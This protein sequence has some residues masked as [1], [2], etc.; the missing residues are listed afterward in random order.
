MSKKSVA[1]VGA[2][3][4]GLMAAEVLSQYNYDI[5]VFEQMPSAA[6]KFLMAGKTGL[7]ISH[8][9]ELSQFIHRYDQVEW[10]KPWITQ[11]DA[12]WIRAWMDDLGVTSYVG[13]S[14]RIFPL[15]MKA[16][17]LLRAWLKILSNTGVQFH[18]RHKCT[19]IEQKKL[20]YID[21]SL[22]QPIESEKL[23]DAVVLACGAV[24][25]PK[26]GSDGQWQTWLQQHELQPFVASNVGVEFSWSK[27]M[28]PIFG[29]PL[30]RIQAWTSSQHKVDGDIVITHYGF[31]SGVIY[32]LNRTLRTSKVLFL[33]L[34]PHLSE[35][36]LVRKLNYTKKQ[37]LSNIWRKAGLDQVKIALLREIVEKEL[38]QQ[39][40]KMASQ[41][42]N[43][44]ISIEGF[45]PIEEAI[46]CA[47]GVK[48]NVLSPMLELNSQSGIFCCG[49][50]LDW[51]AP[52]GGYLLTACFATGRIA[53]EGAHLFLCKNN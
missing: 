37:S 35:D 46:S 53:G 11:F 15:E 9:E 27:Y 10:L 36:E 21:T 26:L 7:N 29:Q 40:E 38:W 3:P 51:D 47:G 17:P 52:T 30:K 4:A 45:R 6:R 16:A 5:H 22:N 23:F 50:M 34:L 32:R 2:G 1:I 48:E 8:A 31:E 44:C 13:S 39:P 41:I 25:W 12:Q 33:D 20:T 49:E 14:G 24:S 42:K 19:G 43:L 28:K 18:Y